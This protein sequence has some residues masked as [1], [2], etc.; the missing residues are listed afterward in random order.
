MSATYYTYILSGWDRRL[1]TGATNNLI[2]R[3]DE[4]RRGR[5][6]YTRESSI[7]RLLYFECHSTSAEAF[8]REKQIKSW[9]RMKRIELIESVNPE[10]K[11]LSETI[12]VVRS[13]SSS[14]K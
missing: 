10:W 8:A 2:R 4:H 9:T 3:L 14:R 5:S 11:D 12:G 6:T 1:Y 7:H 13:K